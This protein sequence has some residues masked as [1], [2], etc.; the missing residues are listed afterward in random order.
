MES[1][2]RQILIAFIIAILFVEI[3]FVGIGYYLYLT[4]FGRENRVPPTSVT[5]NYSV[6]EI[7]SSQG[8][9]ECEHANTYTSV[10]KEANCFEFGKMQI[11]CKK[12]EYIL[13]ER[14][15]E[16]EEHK[17][18]SEERWT[19]TKYATIEESGERYKHCCVCNA[20]L[21]ETYTIPFLGENSIY[22]NGTNVNACFTKSSFTQHSVDKYDIVYTEES[23]IGLN[24]PFILG[25]NY[26]NL[27]SLYQTQIGEHIYLC[28]NGI[29]EVYEV[30]VSEYG[31]SIC[32]STDIIGKSTGSSILDTYDYKTLHL[33]T[34]Y[35]T[36]RNGRWI[37]LA[38][39]IF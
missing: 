7:E 32:D 29:T 9:K 20:I 16:K 14:I 28:I 24:N 25:H 22:I 2:V 13:E 15:L 8:I 35:G 34:C 31:V 17:V 23:D 30:F 5:T 39:Q 12:C 26:G 10:I 38:K 6:E 37:V 3:E 1:K 21:P 4:T 36:N 19:Y 27:G 18:N 11:I 33:Y